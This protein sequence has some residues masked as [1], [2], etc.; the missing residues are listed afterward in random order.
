MYVHVYVNMY[1][2]MHM[3]TYMHACVCVCVYICMHVCVCIYIWGSRLPPVH[4]KHVPKNTKQDFQKIF[5]ISQTIKRRWNVSW[6]VAAHLGA[7]VT[8]AF[9]T[10]L[11]SIQSNRRFTPFMGS[12]LPAAYSL[13]AASF[14]AD[15]ACHFV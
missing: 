3:H 8:A 5:L 6:K 2:C 10:P 11:A 15:Q 7:L 12:S 4:F 1:T 14:F 9:C 13:N